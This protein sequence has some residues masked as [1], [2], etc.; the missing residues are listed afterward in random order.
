MSVGDGPAIQNVVDIA[1]DHADGAL[2][3]ANE[4]S[5]GATLDDVA[6]VGQEAGVRAAAIGMATAY[7][8]GE[9]IRNG[10]G[11]F[12]SEEPSTETQLDYRGNPVDVAALDPMMKA[13][14]DARSEGVDGITLGVEHWEVAAAAGHVP[15]Q[16]QL[17]EIGEVRDF[18]AQKA[19]AAFDRSFA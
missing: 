2:A 12:A 6:D 16:M 9:M 5:L 11:M 13:L 10:W 1:G 19:A 17:E 7:A 15:S 4:F 18:M 8:A 3:K 14:A